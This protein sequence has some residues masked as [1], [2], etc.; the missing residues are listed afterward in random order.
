[1]FNIEDYL[2]KINCPCCLKDSFKILNSSNYKNIDS[3][4]KL[5]EVY[6]SS[7][8]NIL[9]DQLVQ[10][11]YCSFQYLNPRIISKIIIESYQDTIDET[12]VSQD[13]FRLQTF[14]KSLK[15]IIKIL[16]LQ[17]LSQKH[18]L[19]IGSASGIFLKALKNSGFKEEGYEPSKWMVNYGKE[20]YEIN[21]N[22]GFIDNINDNK[23]FDLISFWD[24]LEHVTD[25]D[26]TLKKVDT[27]SKK[28]AYLIINVPDNDSLACKLM[29]KN[30]PFY[31]NV[32]L[33]YFDKKSLEK[34]LKKYKFKLIKSFPHWQYLSLG[35]VLMRGS[36]YIGF[37]KYFEK[38]FKFLKLSNISFPY[39]MGQTTFIF[40]KSE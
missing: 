23:K 22:Q 33:Y 6:K 17:N 27:I 14:S 9:I 8:D 10:C 7:S 16:N 29:G 4:E 24:V 18:F 13:K 32:H 5:K 39:N 31:L 35:Y 19:D 12:H 11:N 28:N 36:K 1:M 38:I 3:F 25:L 26:K 15:K 34:V 21:I 40:E 20:K 30:W 37:L 2:E